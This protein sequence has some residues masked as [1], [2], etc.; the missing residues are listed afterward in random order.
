MSHRT[1][2]CVV[3]LFAASALLSA[4]RW[5]EPRESHK[6]SLATRG[7]TAA[8][9]DP[10][11]PMLAAAASAPLVNGVMMQDFYV[12]VPQPSGSTSWWTRIKDQ[13]TK[14][15]DAG[16]TAVWLPPAYKGSD[17]IGDVGYGVYD[18][19]DLGEFVQPKS[20]QATRYGTLAQLQDAI[21]ELHAKH[22]QVY[23]DIVMNHMMGGSGEQFDFA[24]QHFDLPTHFV[25]GGRGTTYSN[26]EWHYWN[27]NGYQDANHNWFNWQNGW[28]FTPYA[29]GDAYD[30]LMGCEIRYTDSNNQDELIKW[31]KWIT[32][33]LSLDGYRLDATK[34]IYTPFIKRWLDEV[35]G[36]KFAVSEAWFANLADLQNYAAATEGKTSLFDA[37]LHYVFVDILNQNGPGDMRRLRFAGFTE[38]NGALSVS[39]VENHDTDHGGLDSP[40]VNLKMLA[41]AYILTRDKGYPCVYYKDY[42]D[43]GLGEQIKKLIAIRQSHAFGAGFEHPETDEDVYVYSRAGDSS[44]S[45]LLLILNDGGARSRDIVTPFKN[46]TLSD[47]TGNHAQSV[48]TDAAGKGAFPINA[49]S[50]ATW[51]VQ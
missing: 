29:G 20:D 1:R 5:L 9:R 30:N 35:K 46:A 15:H 13:A 10:F 42:Y 40:V 11:R 51:V 21:A 49:K 31:G 4:C 14:L 6:Q 38:V 16:F 47:Q 23:E 18:R 19:Y 45:G 39:F 50:Y 24:G 28:D 27:F 41:Y 22:I 33:K 8:A 2:V 12:N 48:T 34:H 3:V 17:G 37:P 25:Y 44:H 32:T 7:A 36:S 43:F 26:Y